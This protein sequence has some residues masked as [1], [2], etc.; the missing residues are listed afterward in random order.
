MR[1]RQREDVVL[2]AILVGARNG[3]AFQTFGLLV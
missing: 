2:K 3:T 1:L